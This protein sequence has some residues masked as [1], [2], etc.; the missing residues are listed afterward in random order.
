MA[1]ALGLWPDAPLLN[2]PFAL[3]QFKGLQVRKTAA[4]EDRIYK[5]NGLRD[6]GLI[7]NQKTAGLQPFLRGFQRFPRLR[8]VQ[9]NQIQVLLVHFSVDV[10][11]LYF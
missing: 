2:L 3:D 4:F 11:L 5:I 6:R 1:D 7:G 8:H 9:D 10:L